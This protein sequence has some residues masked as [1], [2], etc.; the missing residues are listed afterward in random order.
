MRL[1]PGAPKGISRAL[2]IK[3]KKIKLMNL[4]LLPSVHTVL[5]H[6]RKINQISYTENMQK[7]RD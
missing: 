4:K 1:W 2:A 5:V 7:K 3:E 6:Y